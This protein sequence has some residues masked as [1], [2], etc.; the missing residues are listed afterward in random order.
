MKEQGYVEAAV[1]Y[2]R[3]GRIHP[4]WRSPGTVTGRL[5]GSGGI[6]IQ[7]L[8]SSE[9][10]L[11]NYR[12]LPG[13]IWLDSDVKALEP[14]VLAEYSKDEGFLEVY[15]PGKVNDIYLF[16]GYNIPD[17]GKEFKK[18][19]YT[20]FNPDPETIRLCKKE[21]KKLR[22][23]CKVVH[24]AKS[25]GAGVGRIKNGLEQSGFAMSFEEV[26][27]ICDAWDDTFS[28]VKKFEKSLLDEWRDNGGWILDGLG[29][30]APVADTALK[31]ILNRFVQRT[32]HSILMEYLTYL[33]GIA[34]DRGFQFS[35]LI[36]D[37]HDQFLVETKLDNAKLLWETVNE[38]EDELN[39]WLDGDIRIQFDPQWIEN[40]AAAKVENYKASDDFVH[41]LEKN[42]LK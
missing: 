36:S 21:C 1:K 12:P 24:L 3:V 37:F 33:R 5:A 32:G 16:F 18:R 28:G 38:A 4:Q 22:G 9:K 19:G 35:W 40:F 42:G 20:P 23:V 14:T 34:G 11:V 39:K 15:G 29:G 2:D 6:N 10:Y 31:D 17:I 7:Q 13:M 25:Y 30:V 26:E 41:M 27:R 8:P